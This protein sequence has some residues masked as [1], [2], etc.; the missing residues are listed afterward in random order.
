MRHIEIGYRLVA[1]ESFLLLI[2]SF[3]KTFAANVL[4]QVLVNVL[5][6]VCVSF[7]QYS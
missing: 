6:Q 4:I 3:L 1:S 5:I 2:L 7:C